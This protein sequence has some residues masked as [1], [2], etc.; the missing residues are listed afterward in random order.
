MDK[1]LE[2]S[3]NLRVIDDN[4]FQMFIASCKPSFKIITFSKKTVLS[5]VHKKEE[6]LN[7]EIKLFDWNAIALE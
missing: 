5:P 4:T 2:E 1:I 6:T 7:V 3:T